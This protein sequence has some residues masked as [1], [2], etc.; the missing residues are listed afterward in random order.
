MAASGFAFAAK[1]GRAWRMDIGRNRRSALQ[2]ATAFSP[3]LTAAAATYP[4][5]AERFVEEGAQ[6]AV[7]DALALTDEDVDF[8]GSAP[9]KGPAPGR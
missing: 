5:I 6:S 9:P 8:L 1:S 7:A 2:R 3:F 4:E